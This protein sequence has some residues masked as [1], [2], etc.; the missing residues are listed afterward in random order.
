MRLDV[1]RS[2]EGEFVYQTLFAVFGTICVLFAEGLDRKPLPVRD[3]LGLIHSGKIA[4]AQLF[5]RPKH[6]MKSLHIQNPCQSPRKVRRI[7]AIKVQTFP[8]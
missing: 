7:L 3:S 6:L 5:N 4:R 2:E 8:L 1:E